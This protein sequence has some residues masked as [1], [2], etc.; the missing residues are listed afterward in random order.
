MPTTTL[1]PAAPE[2]IPSAWPIFTPPERALR[3]AGNPSVDDAQRIVILTGAGAADRV[4]ARRQPARYERFTT[5]IVIVSSAIMMAFTGVLHFAN[6]GLETQT[7]ST[8]GTHTG[9][10]STGDAGDSGGTAP[11]TH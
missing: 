9:F 11:G 2:T 8:S 1:E 4:G 5:R 6:A 10:S 3:S 7:S